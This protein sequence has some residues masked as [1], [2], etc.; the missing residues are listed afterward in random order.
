M[1]EGTPPSWWFLVL[2]LSGN[3]DGATKGALRV[4]VLLQCPVEK[5]IQ[6]ELGLS[7]FIAYIP[8]IYFYS[9]LASRSPRFS[10]FTFVQHD[11]YMWRLWQ[12]IPDYFPFSTFYWPCLISY[13]L[14]VIF[15]QWS[16]HYHYRYLLHSCIMWSLAV[17]GYGFRNWLWRKRVRCP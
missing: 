3:E 1:Y 11:D 2:S 5:F 12:W 10:L 16:V 14:H 6:W 8:P 9:E 7:G 13:V 17:S 4:K 15:F